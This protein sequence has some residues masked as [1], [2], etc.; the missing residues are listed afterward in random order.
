MITTA[1]HY[2]GLTPPLHMGTWEKWFAQVVSLDMRRRGLSPPW[3][4]SNLEPLRTEVRQ[5]AWQVACPGPGCR[6]AE[7]AW[8]EGLFMCLS[9]FNV[10]I[11]HLLRRSYF[12]T[13]RREIEALLEPRLLPNRNWWRADSLADLE[14]EN[15]EH[16]L[17]SVAWKP[18]LNV[19]GI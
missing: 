8:E 13:E 1:N 17:T 19:G 7:L 5:G 18:R 11:D 6:G 4:I 10:G 15:A 3:G 16:G 12:P 9:C 14:R 2:F